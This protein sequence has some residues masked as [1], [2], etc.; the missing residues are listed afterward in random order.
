[1]EN[2]YPPISIFSRTRL[3]NTCPSIH[4]HSPP[5][6]KQD[7]RRNLNHQQ[8]TSTPNELFFFPSCR[9]WWVYLDAKNKYNICYPHNEDHITHI[10][11]NCKVSFKYLRFNSRLNTCLLTTKCLVEA[12]LC[13]IDFIL[14]V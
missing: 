9:G 7:H 4:P 5:L 14:I 1:M 2:V 13:T 8:L 10:F 6:N 12:F 11:E 3:H